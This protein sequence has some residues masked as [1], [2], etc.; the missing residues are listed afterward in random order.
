MLV[1]ARTDGRLRL[2]RQHD[3]ALLSGALAMGWVGVERE[4]QPLSFD[5]VLATALHDLSW[6]EL[7][8]EPS[9]DGQSG[10]PYSF[11][12]LPLDAKLEAYAR[13]LD[14]IE[15]LSA[16][17]ALLVSL[18][19]ASFLETAPAGGFQDAEARRRRRLCAALG[20]DAGSDEQ[21]MEEL[22]YLQMFDSLSI[23]LSLTPPAADARVQPDWVDDLRHL[24]SPDGSL[25][26]LTWLAEDLLYVD[27]FPFRG[28]LP[29][30]LTY[31]ELP[32]QEFDSQEE[33][34]SVWDAA[35]ESSWMVWLRPAPR[36]A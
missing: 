26:H 2:F 12:T 31:R 22:A 17:A 4:P 8:R 32:Q 29:L 10:H 34:V 13:G 27:P 5:L 20:V 19:Y 3:H 35:P 11:Q 18:H 23:F 15:R 6:Y 36:L 1:Q 21:L 33:L 7:D 14:Q 24:T 16:Y 28:A 30:Q 25:L 9:L